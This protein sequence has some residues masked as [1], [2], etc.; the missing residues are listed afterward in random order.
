MRSI[1]HELRIGV[2]I[3]A[4][5]GAYALTVWL[6]LDSAGQVHAFN[7]FGYSS[8]V[9]GT[10]AVAGCLVFIA[11][12]LDLTLR[13]RPE[14]P[15]Q[16]MVADMRREILSP[17][18]LIMRA[19]PFIMLLL[20][21]G[22]FTTFKSAIPLFKPFTYDSLFMQWDRLIFGTDPWRI[23]HRWLGGTLPTM[24]LQQAYNF[25][26][27]LM[28]VS[29]IYVVMRAD[30]RRFRTQY[31]LAFALTWI[32]LGS[33]LAVV[34]SSAGPCYYGRVVPGPDVYAPLMAKLHSMDSQIAASG[35][36][37]RLFA[38]V[39]QEKL[40]TAY[41]NRGEMLGG[42][43]SAMPSLHVGVSILMARAAFELNTRLGV[44]LSL[45]ALIIWVGSVHLGWHYAVDG[46]VALPAVLM[47]WGLAG[48]L[49]DWLGI[50][51]L[52][53]RTN[54]CL[55]PLPSSATVPAE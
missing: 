13:Q 49:V 41:V 11:Y 9:A 30:F 40:W 16:V 7:L 10:W 55:D 48:R 51:D 28:W 3:L 34:L 23:T 21:M 24:I 17:D 4:L 46:L 19:V 12:A 35:S 5:L 20:L 42:G 45:Y 38:L 8:L 52:D 53:T 47:I 33:L 15:L 54:R 26:F 2:L 44:V 18:R 32:G 43:I 1:H 6:A 25:W 31:L 14:R 22:S 27:F 50:T 36:P 29:V 39:V 37:F